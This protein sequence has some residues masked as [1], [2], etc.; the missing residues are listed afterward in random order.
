MGLFYLK[1]IEF[2]LFLNFIHLFVSDLAVA[3]SGGWSMQGAICWTRLCNVCR[4][5][6]KVKLLA[7]YY[8]FGF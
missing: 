3:F 5:V 4:Y 1:N 8:L 6:G 7:L 2:I